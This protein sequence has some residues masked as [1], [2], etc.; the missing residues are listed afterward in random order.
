MA[1]YIAGDVTTRVQLMAASIAGELTTRVQLMAASIAGD[2]TTRVS[3][4]KTCT[5]C[6]GVAKLA[7]IFTLLQYKIVTLLQL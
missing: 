1:A 5:A 7:L 2:L 3:K 6:I 4:C